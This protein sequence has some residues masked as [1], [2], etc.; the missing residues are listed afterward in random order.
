MAEHYRFFNSTA[1]DEREYQASD[2]AEYFGLF[3]PDGT[4]IEDGEVGLGVTPGSGL[5]VEVGTGFANI[6]GYFY[7]N[8]AEKVFELDPA[9]SVLDRIDRVVLKLDIVNRYMRLELKKGTLGSQPS[10]PALVDDASTKE[11]PIAQIR[12][13]HGAVSI[14]AGNIADE[15]E[16]IF[17]LKEG[18]RTF[19][20]PT[21]PPAI[22]AGDQW[23]KEV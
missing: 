14:T 13:N 2:F 1:G 10:P 16:A 19:S 6:R 8:D 7:K 12:V 20:G 15:R 9:D 18:V 4:Y 21:E 23:F 17:S 5:E 22:K 3:V 11:I